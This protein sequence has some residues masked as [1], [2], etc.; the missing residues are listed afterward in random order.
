MLAQRRSA[1]AHVHTRT[2]C[3][4][5]SVQIVEKI[6]TVEITHVREVGVEKVSSGPLP[7]PPSLP[8]HLC[9]CM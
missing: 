1:L 5:R 6:V 4:P 9:L 2:F 3:L 7:P 8:F